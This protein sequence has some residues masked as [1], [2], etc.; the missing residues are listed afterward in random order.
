MVRVWFRSRNLQLD[1]NQP[2]LWQFN[3]AR[4]TAAIGVDLAGGLCLAGSL[5][6]PSRSSRLRTVACRARRARTYQSCY[7]ASIMANA[8]LLAGVTMTD[9]ALAYL[10][11]LGIVG[12]GVLWIV[13]GTNAAAS[14]IGTLTIAVGLLSLV[15]ELHNRAH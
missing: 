4:P 3:Y 6:I 12:F 8:D 13:E 5:R 2:R 1:P 14:A 9:T 10:I 11:S 15:S 7:L